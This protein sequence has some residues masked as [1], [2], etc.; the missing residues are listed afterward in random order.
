MGSPYSGTN[1]LF[2]I[3]VILPY[4]IWGFSIGI[5]FVHASSNNRSTWFWTLVAFIPFFGILIYF[6]Y[7]WYKTD[8]RHGYLRRKKLERMGEY[9]AKPRTPRE[10]EEHEQIAILA[11][12]R[13]KEIEELLL[14]GK[15]EDAIAKIEERAEEAVEKGDKT[16][17]ETYGF[18]RQ[19]AVKYR[20]TLSLPRVLLHL[21][22][23]KDQPEEPA[24]DIEPEETEPSAIGDHQ[25]GEEAEEEIYYDQDDDRNRWL[26]I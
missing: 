13:D 3:G 12:Y 15:A 23:K 10:K 7:Y 1:I 6:I 14:D 18:Y 4:A 19:S 8:T 25:E 16:A 26:E 22:G 11:N 9:I 21:W 2:A 20:H 5:V 17:R 24:E